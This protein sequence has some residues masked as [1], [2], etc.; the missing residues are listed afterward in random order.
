MAGEEVFYQD[1]KVTVTSSRFVVGATMY[2]TRNISSVTAEEA[3]VPPARG[4]SIFVGLL[5]AIVGLFAGHAHQGPA[6]L[7]HP[8]VHKEQFVLKEG[9]HR[10]PVRLVLGIQGMPP[11]GAIRVED[12]QAMCRAMFAQTTLHRLQRD[13]CR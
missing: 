4:F 12:N 8:V 9:R 2:P 1:D 3:H 6:G 13:A 5:A 7:M 11:I 10:L